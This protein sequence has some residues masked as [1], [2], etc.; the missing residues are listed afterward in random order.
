MIKKRVLYIGTPI[1]NYYKKIISEFEAQDFSVDYYNDRPNES[2]LVKGMIKINRNILHHTIN[3]YL[4]KIINETKDKIYDLVFIINCKSFDS[5]MI[6]RLRETHKN[7]KF[8]LYMWDSLLLY[9]DSKEIIPIFDKTYSFDLEDCINNSN[10]TFMPLF[11]CKEYEEAGRESKSSNIEYDIASICTAHPNRYKIMKELFPMLQK[12]GIRIFSY[13]YINKLQFWY[14]KIYVEEFKKA[15]SNEFKFCPLSETNNLS[16]LKKTN[17]V[18]DIRHNKQSGLTMRT[19]E[20]L[21]ANKKLI[22][23]NPDIKIYDFY[24]ENNIL[25]INKDNWNDI[26]MFLKNNHKQIDKEIYKKYSL[27][28]WLSSIIKQE[29]NNYLLKPLED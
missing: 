2:S 22:T 25:I 9:P 7:A 3:K 11:Y 13:M 10:L 4:N 1:F 17:T 23:N 5:D 26:Y 20:T 28:S 6:K 8:V 12:N 27:N 29:S 14:N 24:N 21:G 15:K 18:F 19:I 16:I